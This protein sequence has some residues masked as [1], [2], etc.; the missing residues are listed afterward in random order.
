MKLDQMIIGLLIFSTIFITG[1]LVF[2]NVNENYNLEADDTIFE[3]ATNKED[4]TSVYNVLNQT[5]YEVEKIKQK[6]VGGDL[7]RRYHEEAYRF[8]E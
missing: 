8:G 4:N 2:N 1:A 5:S 3:G 7:K 6:M